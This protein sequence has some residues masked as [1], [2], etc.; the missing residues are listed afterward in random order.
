MLTKLALDDLLVLDEPGDNVGRLNIIHQQL[1]NKLSVLQSYDNEILALCNV[2]DIDC[3][4]E[5]SEPVSVKV[6]DYQ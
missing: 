5:E 4:I 2:D 6:L 1:K 3:K